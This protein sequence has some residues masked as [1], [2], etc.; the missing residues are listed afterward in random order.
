MRKTL[1]GVAIAALLS[2]PAFA[3]TMPVSQPSNTTTRPA[4][5]LSQEQVESRIAAAGFKEVKD[6]EFKHGIWQG[7]ARGGDDNWVDV[8]VHP[9]TGKIFKEG[10]PSALNKQEVEAKVTAAGY[11]KVHDADFE[12]G[13]WQAEA[14]NG[15]GKDVEL[16]VDPDD[17]S[18]I[19]E[20]E[21]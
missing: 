10:K 4:N 12:D 9:V 1:I 14:T 11:Q 5:A 19:S 13:L 6:L 15:K 18:V 17:G 16:I 20:E 3:D 7:A 21:D 8:S 2:A